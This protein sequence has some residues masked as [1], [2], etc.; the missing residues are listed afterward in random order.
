MPRFSKK[1]S[2]VKNLEA[3]AKSRTHNGLYGNTT[4]NR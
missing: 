2:F 4:E 1:A 3:V